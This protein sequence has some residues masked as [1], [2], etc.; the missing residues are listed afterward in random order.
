[1]A[2][3]FTP[4]YYPGAKAQA[5]VWQQIINRFPPHTHY[6][7][8]FLGSGQ[9]LRHKRPAPVYSVGLEV[10]RKV[11]NTYWEKYPR[12]TKILPVDAIQWLR[13]NMGHMEPTTLIYLDPPY[14]M[15][16]RR[17]QRPLY[18]RELTDEQHEELLL[19]LTQ[20]NPKGC[21]VALSSYPNELYERFL[22]GW[23]WA[24]IETANH[25]GRATEILWMNYPTPV[26][27]HQYDYIGADTLERRIIRRQIARNVAKFNRM[28]PQIRAA[29]LHELSNPKP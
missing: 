3:R 6:V 14:P 13:D 16:S 21:M 26:A 20:H 24:E 1:M 23:N 19:T 25:G 15:D 11:I 2:R 22:T 7:E 8:A 4:D 5:V 17:S 10:N 28:D 18:E 27:L 9:I 29:I 12:G